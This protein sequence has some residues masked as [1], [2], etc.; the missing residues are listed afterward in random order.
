[1]SLR[2]W[3]I[4]MMWGL[5]CGIL[6]G[7][8]GTVGGGVSSAQNAF[9]RLGSTLTIDRLVTTAGTS[10]LGGHSTSSD[11]FGRALIKNGSS[12]Y[13]MTFRF[14][15]NKQNDLAAYFSN[16]QILRLVLLGGFA[17]AVPLVTTPVTVTVPSGH[18]AANNN[19]VLADAALR[20][21]TFD[22]QL[23]GS[24]YLT[25]ITSA[26]IVVADD[27]RTMAGGD[28]GAFFFIAQKAS[29]IP[30]AANEDLVAPFTLVDFSV[31]AQGGLR[32]EDLWNFSSV[33]AGGGG[34]E[35]FRMTTPAGARREGEFRLVDSASGIF[36]FGFD[37]TV[38]DGAPT[39]SQG[40]EG[41]LLLSPDRE[42]LLAYDL[43]GATYWAGS[44]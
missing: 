19:L 5:S 13:A 24:A 30:S 20:A 15:L 40:V 12:L 34:E 35:A 43:T 37:A 41:C 3:W 10:S 33:G 11:Y 6:A 18:N 31:G 25:R 44:R 38:G 27:F 4:R 14:T 42:L 32:F 22:L 36:V 29:S 28:D 39:A 26:G 17:N 16:F 9:T 21:A 2:R 7:C 8:V 1:M 23:T